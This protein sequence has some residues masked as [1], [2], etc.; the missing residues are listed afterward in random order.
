MKKNTTLTDVQSALL[1][2]GSAPIDPVLPWQ[3]LADEN[4][5]CLGIVAA[6]PEYAALSS[7]RENG[8]I[9]GPGFTRGLMDLIRKMTAQGR[10]D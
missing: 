2:V 3:A 5:R 8:E 4:D 7:R 6:T 9:D 10:L 1:S